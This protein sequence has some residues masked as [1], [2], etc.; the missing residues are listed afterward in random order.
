MAG[1]PSSLRSLNRWPLYRRVGGRAFAWILWLGLG[2][3]LCALLATLMQLYGARSDNKTI[4]ALER[5]ED[6]VVVE[7]ASPEVSFARLR[8]LAAVGR[9]DEA[10]PWVERLA[11]QALVQ[12]GTVASEKSTDIAVWS[13]YNMGNARLRQALELLGSTRTEE[14]PSLVRLAKEYYVRAL[15]LDAS[16]WDARYNLDIASRLV[17]DLPPAEV[18]EED[19]SP[20]K[21]KRLWTD[22]PGLP[23]GLP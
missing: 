17:R 6:I 14:A 20:E 3:T 11:A 5:R 15:R 1:N 10:L 23:K 7:Q 9:L 13:L 12:D 8:F 21:P 2:L 18:S 22:L 4:D 19:E 16:F